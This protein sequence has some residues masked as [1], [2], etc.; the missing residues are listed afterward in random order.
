M[1]AATMVGLPAAA[2]P[3][4]IVAAGLEEPTDRYPHRVLGA[5][6]EHAALRVTLSDGHE[7]LIRHAPGMVFE[8]V[9]ARVLDVTGDG[10]PEVLVTESHADLGARVAVYGL[11]GGA[12]GAPTVAL[13]GATPF[14]GTRFRWFAI[15]GAADLTGDGQVEIAAVDRPHLA[16]TLRIWRV[17]SAPDR[18]SLHQIASVP[19]VT[20]HRIGEDFI[21]GG[22]RHCPGGAFPEIVLAD[23]G[24]Q[25]IK[26]IHLQG[27]TPATRRITGP[28][29][30]STFARVLRCAD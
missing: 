23:T 14:I 6:P 16:R 3:L 22:I 17:E 19:A 24:W 20:N 10:A 21:S 27:G 11:V 7:W 2:G 8:D 18:L 9:A 29:D 30:A 25:W 15:V 1:L 13:R 4:Q 26:G 5:T 28:A 12:D